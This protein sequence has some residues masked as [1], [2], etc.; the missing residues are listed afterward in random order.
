MVR[1]GHILLPIYR[2]LLKYEL[3]NNRENYK[4]SITYRD[5][6]CLFLGSFR[7]IVLSN[8]FLLELASRTTMLGRLW[9]DS[10]L[11]NG[12][13]YSIKMIIVLC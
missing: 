7:L 3:L 13:M 2:K 1:E 6:I 4:Y 5:F 9:S 8:Q 10:I 11:A 12:M